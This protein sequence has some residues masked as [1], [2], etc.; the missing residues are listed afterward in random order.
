MQKV[1]VDLSEQ[2]EDKAELKEG[3]KLAPGDHPRTAAVGEI[4]EVGPGHR[5]WQPWGPVADGER[6]APGGGE[7]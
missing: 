6:K 7:L 1:V 3:A 2:E 5:R 4:C